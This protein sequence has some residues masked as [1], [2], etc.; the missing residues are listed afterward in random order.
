MTRVS[1]KLLLHDLIGYFS[2][3]R[4]QLCNPTNI[5]PR[6]FQ[7]HFPEVPNLKLNLKVPD[8]YKVIPLDEGA[9]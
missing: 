2:V 3:L 6:R 7:A 1:K 9:L 5:R 8:F 4:N